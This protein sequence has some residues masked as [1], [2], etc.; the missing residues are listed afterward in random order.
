[1]FASSNESPSGSSGL[2]NTTSGFFK[3]DENLNENFY[4]HADPSKSSKND[5]D[6]GR[7]VDL[8]YDI[9]NMFIR[10]SIIYPIG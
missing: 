7:L 9:K 10:Y 1:M 8:S 5:P 6:H 3:V 2:V 4:D